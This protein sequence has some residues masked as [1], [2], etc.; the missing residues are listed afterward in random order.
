MGDEK[1]VPWNNSPIYPLKYHDINFGT[2]RFLGS[3]S[4][5]LKKNEFEPTPSHFF[6]WCHLFCIYLDVVPFFINDKRTVIINKIC[7]MTCSRLKYRVWSFIMKR[8][9]GSKNTYWV[10]PNNMALISF[11]QQTRELFI[12]K[13]SQAPAPAQLAGLVSLNFT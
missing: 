1:G 8:G 13:L 3:H 12:A 9:R 7:C 2:R 6:E 11:C 10:R 5:Y 4:F